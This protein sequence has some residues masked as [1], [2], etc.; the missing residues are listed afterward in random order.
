MNPY[1]EVGISRLSFSL[2]G[3]AFLPL[4]VL[5][6]I[7]G[8]D[9]VQLTNSGN[10]ENGIL[11]DASS[12]GVDQNDVRYTKS[13]A[14]IW[15]R[16][17][18][19]SSRSNEVIAY[20]NGKPPILNQDVGWTNG[21]DSVDVSFDDKYRVPFYIWIVKGPYDSQSSIALN[22]AIT[23]SQI[24][25]D[26]RQG[27]G[28]SR[29]LINDA[30]TDVDASSFHA[31]NCGKASDMKIRV[32]FDSS[33]V[34]VYYVD[35]VDFGSGA[36]TTNGVWCGGN[37]VVM[38]RNTSDHLFAHEIGHAFGLGH[39][40]GLTGDFD[41]TNV[42]HNAS[43]NR[44]YLTEGQTFRA[45]YHP[46]SAINGVYNLRPGLITRNCGTS[47]TTADF[48]CPAVQTRIW[49]DGTNWPPD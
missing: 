38:G 16:N 22:A 12:G 43:N 21:W 46:N 18:K 35:T 34:N 27:I 13:G 2:S 4:L 39:V 45:V 28:F 7:S 33:G 3:L 26:E 15:M 31:F 37:V 1:Q 47:T 8:C 9:K 11:V 10:G 29:F 36:G 32:G 30:T 5:V 23:T 20:T 25:S 49:A 6:T 44:A 48:R 17:Y 19:P 42:M 41:T 40:N 24:W 14:N